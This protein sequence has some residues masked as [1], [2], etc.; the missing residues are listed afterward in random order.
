MVVNYTFHEFPGFKV[1]CKWFWQHRSLLCAAAKFSSCAFC[2][3][4]R[5]S[6]KSILSWTPQTV[7]AISALPFAKYAY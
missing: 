4:D 7:I 3:V 5:M 6:K 1:P 2:H